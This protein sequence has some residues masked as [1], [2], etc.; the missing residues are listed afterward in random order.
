MRDS[1]IGSFGVLALIVS[2]GLRAAALAAMPR[3][4]EAGLALIA[5]HAASRAGL[6]PASCLLRAGAEDGLGA[7]AGRPAAAPSLVAVAIGAAVAIGMLGPWRGACRA[8]GDGG[9]GR[10]HRDACAA[11]DRRLHRRR[12]GRGPAIGEI[13]MLLVAAAHE[14]SAKSKG[15]CS[16][17]ARSAQATPAARR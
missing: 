13:V 2:I 11:P 7:A 5:A 17:P 8:R 3:P 15:R 16:S 10:R 1:R 6:P 9:G 14:R 12:A 4:V